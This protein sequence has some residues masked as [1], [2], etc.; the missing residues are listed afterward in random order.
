MRRA[1]LV[2]GVGCLLATLLI[3]P[4]AAEDWPAYKHDAGRSG[5]TAEALDFPLAQTW[6]RRPNQ[7]PAPAW[8][9]PGKEMHRMDFD[10]APQ[11]VVAGGLVYLASSSD[12]TVR[13][14]KADTGEFIWRFITDGPLRF[15]PAIADGRAYVA[16][17]DGWVYCLNAATGA[18]VWRFHAAPGDDQLLGNDRMIS[19][20][21][22]RSGPIVTDGIV[23]CTAGMWPTEG[24]Y[25]YALDAAT[26]EEIWC[27]DSSGELYLD[28]P[29][30]GASGFSGVAPQGYLLVR[31]DALLVATG[32]CV[33][34]AFD[35]HTGRLLYYKPAAALYHGSSRVT[36]VED[37]YFNSKNNF[38]NPSQAYVGD[39]APRSGDGMFAYSFASGDV[40]FTL[41]SRYRVLGSDGVVY[42][43]GGQDVRAYSLD[44]LREKRGGDD[45]IRWTAPHTA[46]VYC[47]AMAG[48]TLLLGCDGLITALDSADGS[49]VWETEVAGQV[50]GLAIS[51]GRL[52]ATLGTGAVICFEA[53]AQGEPS[54]VAEPG[55]REPHPRQADLLAT[56]LA[57]QAGK[58]KGYALAI[59]SREAGLAEALAART[60]LHVVAVLPNADAVAAERERLL[61][62]GLYGKRVWVTSVNDAAHLPFA[63]YFA[64]LVVVAGAVGGVSPAECYRALRPCGGALCFAGMDAAER[65]E[66][67]AA[68]DIPAGEVSE[69]RSIIVRGELP[70]AGTWRY[71]WADGG[72]T[73]VS[74][75]KRVRLPPRARVRDRAG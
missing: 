66:F 29:H 50:R 35:R 22:S 52:I 14:F 70:G 56:Q 28:L 24:V 33:P 57:R 21:P 11:P 67:I 9:Q 17:D 3:G 40:V 45:L 53:G 6:A 69:D 38:T 7:P 64:D 30:P 49:A 60:E 18:L 15:A 62:T 23:Y 41:Q 43:V 58:L 5:V 42:A 65:A 59:G 37:L 16:S 31:G 36:S 55:L 12:D 20:W 8:V 44:M 74:A 25:I 26:G 71:P 1:L 47:I 51:D 46:R 32:R 72:R 10:Y 19:R 48:G 27:N 73:G 68:A 61:A 54:V 34:A 2:I 63:P 39:R 4:G 13:A 75:D